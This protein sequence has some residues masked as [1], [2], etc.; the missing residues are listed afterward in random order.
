MSILNAYRD[1][2]RVFLRWLWFSFVLGLL[3]I[4]FRFVF[5]YT[6]DESKY[7]AASYAA[8]FILI[9]LFVVAVLPFLLYWVSEWTGE[10]VA[11]R[12]SRRK[13]R[14]LAQGSLPNQMRRMV[15]HPMPTPKVATEQDEQ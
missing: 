5:E 1:G 7:G 15:R 10:F 3:Q 14:N 9:V 6:V 13:L 12:I 8:P 11:P 4:P 2:W